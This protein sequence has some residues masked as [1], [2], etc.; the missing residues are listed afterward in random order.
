[1]TVPTSQEHS[2]SLYIQTV[3]N[4]RLLAQNLELSLGLA[5]AY[6]EVSSGSKVSSPSRNFHDDGAASFDPCLRRES[7]HFEPMI[8]EQQDRGLSNEDPSFSPQ[9]IDFFT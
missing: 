3:V 9:L 6:G 8:I 5:G 1:M 2:N 7:L 4:S